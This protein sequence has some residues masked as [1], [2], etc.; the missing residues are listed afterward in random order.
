MKRSMMRIAAAGMIATTIL[1]GSTAP[2]FAVV[3]TKKPNPDIYPVQMNTYYGT[4]A[5]RLCR[6]KGEGYVKAEDRQDYWCWVRDS[7]Y[8]ATLYLTPV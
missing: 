5:V 4:N 1:L 8:R 7:G 2:A 3:S 6:S